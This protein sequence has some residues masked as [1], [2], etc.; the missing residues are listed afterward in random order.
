M[1]LGAMCLA[2]GAQ[3]GNAV[4][5]A[6]AMLLSLE[7]AWNGAELKHDAKALDLLLADIFEYTDSDGT[8]MNRIQWLEHVKKG[9]D[10]YDDQLGNS[11]MTVRV[12]GNS[13][14]VTGQY[15]ERTK[16]KGKIVVES[17]RFTDVW[18]LQNGTWK[19]AASQSTAIR[20]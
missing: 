2:A 1:I 11:G 9:V 4:N 13:A 7:N 3:D 15:R 10:Q 16:V 5:E 19:C 6:S 18:I 12:Y 14:V 8:F 17:G 20:H